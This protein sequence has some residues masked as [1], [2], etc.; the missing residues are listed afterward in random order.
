MT[1]LYILDYGVVGGATKAFV[2]LVH[3]MCQN[4][5]TP[6]VV[7]GKRSQLNEMLEQKGI[8]TIEAGHYTA[9]AP[10]S[11]KRLRWPLSYLKRFLQYWCSEYFAYRKLCREIDFSKIDLI[12]TNSARNSLGGRLSRKKGIPHIVHIRE[13]ADKD[14]NCISFIPNYIFFLNETSTS[15][16]S[17]SK[18]VCNYWNDKGID[19]S[20]NNVIY[21]GVNYRDIKPKESF[22]TDCLRMV[23]VGGV[24]PTKGQHLAVEAIGK[25]PDDIRKHVS[26]DI[27]GWFDANYVNEMK[28]YSSARGFQGNIRFLGAVND[29]HDRLCCYDI[30]LMCSKSEGFGLVTAEYMHAGLGV[31]AS[32]SGACPE[33]VDHRETGLL[34]KSGDSDDLAKRILEFY[35][36]RTLLVNCSKKARIKAKE[37]FTDEINAANI[38]KMYKNI[39]ENK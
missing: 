12:H 5:I 34:F 31:I 4:D 23:M 9:L 33:I 19:P 14:F 16:I 10:F 20:K 17:V 28:N 7:T 2:D 11:F 27:L 39:L 32:D 22:H 13:F 18:S 1:V 8:C 15:F 30:G 38:I 6:I 36:D 25:L 35:N 24:V 29:V 37:R 26:L 21:D 3:Q